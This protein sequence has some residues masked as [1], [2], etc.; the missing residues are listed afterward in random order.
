[1]V[2]RRRA[3]S[4][5]AVLAILTAITF[6]GD[7]RPARSANTKVVVQISADVVSDGRAPFSA[8]GDNGRGEDDG[9]TNGRVRVG[10][11]VTY[12]IEVG[13]NDPTTSIV[14]RYPVIV[15][16]ATLPIGFT[17]TSIPTACSGPDSDLLNDDRVL[18][19]DLGSRATGSSAGFNAVV[20]VA[21]DVHEGK[22]VRP[23]FRVSSSGF[24]DT[25]LDYPP[26]VVATSAAPSFDLFKSKVTT[27]VYKV[28]NGRAGY[29]FD[30]S[31]AIR[32]SRLVGMEP[33]DNSVTFVEN[34]DDVAPD[35]RLIGCTNSNVS[36]SSLPRTNNPSSNV[37]NF[38]S[39]T[40]RQ[41]GTV[42][43]T[44][45]EGAQV[46]TVEGVD[47]Q[48]SRYPTQTL[49]GGSIP[50]SEGIVHVGTLQVWIPRDSFTDVYLTSRNKLG[51]LRGT[52]AIT[53]CF[54]GDA[55]QPGHPDYDDAE[56]QL[57]FD[58]TCS[59]KFNEPGLGKDASDV[60]ASA[61][62]ADDGSQNHW[63]A[64]LYEPLGA[65]VQKYD[66]VWN[67]PTSAVPNG[68]V[69]YTGLSRFN[70]PVGSD[71][72]TG[73]GFIGRQTQFFSR[74]NFTGIGLFDFQPGLIL[75]TTIDNNVVRVD[76]L[77]GQSERAAW[78]DTSS[79]SAVISAAREA[80]WVIEYGVGGKDGSL[81][82]KETYDGLPTWGSRDDQKRGT[83]TDD[84]SAVWTQ[85][86]TSP[87]L[88]AYGG[89]W[90]VTKIRFRTTS[91]WTAESQEI[92]GTIRPSVSLRVRSAA[93]VGAIGAN[94]LNVYLPDVGWDW[95]ISSYNATTAK[96]E[97]G[98]RI[99]VTGTRV[100]IAK[101]VDSANV[102][103]GSGTPI[104]YTLQ[105][106]ITATDVEN[107]QTSHQ[108][109]VVDT[110]PEGVRYVVGSAAPS[111]DKVTV[112]LNGSTTLRWFLGDLTANE[113][114]TPITYQAMV[115]EDVPTG[116]YV[117][118]AVISSYFPGEAQ[119]SANFE[120]VSSETL[121][122]STATV[123][124]T[125]S[126]SF[127]IVKRTLTPRVEIG[128]QFSFDVSAVNL[129]ATTYNATSIIDWLPATT[130][131]RIAKSSFN[132]GVHVVSVTSNPGNSIAAEDLP[133]G[134]QIEYT[135]FD[136]GAA[137]FPADADPDTISGTIGWCST[138]GTPSTN[139]PASI[140]DTTA[141]RITT[142]TFEPGQKLRIRILLEPTQGSGGSLGI[143][144]RAGDVYTN[145]AVMRRQGTGIVL[146]S[147]LAAV[148]VGA[149]SLGDYVWRD[150]DG[151]G[152]QNGNEP[153]LSGVRVRLY[154]PNPFTG[155]PV[156]VSIGLD[157]ILGT[158]DDA[159]GGVVTN[160]QG[161]YSFAN[162]PHGR[163]IIR[164]DKP[165]KYVPTRQSVGDDSTIDSD[166][167]G[168]GWSMWVT[169]GV[170]SDNPNIDAGFEPVAHVVS[171]STTLSLEDTTYPSVGSNVPRVLAIMA[172]LLATGFVLRYGAGQRR[173]TPN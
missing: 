118:R 158:I 132:G 110:L 26:I 43:C 86:L 106:T 144:N 131:P 25:A 168:D 24:T 125:N 42:S 102:N 133:T 74:P 52:A 146:Q 105:P 62:P 3:T 124:V 104:N 156:E 8:A 81:A 169:L 7:A 71:W 68:A 98:D 100:R 117:N 173:Q 66:S 87:Q 150:S 48:P 107:D 134:I 41:N 34:V 157:G 72:R 80:G 75:C 44:T 95:L 155:E 137:T 84:D 6:F 85:D 13:L 59:G 121:R 61:N 135:D 90:A 152:L 92:A 120:D 36:F 94:Y 70:S 145:N 65:R 76:P 45:G 113:A 60:L 50:T 51:A 23:S 56:P 103:A 122:S 136:P 40:I 39:A 142:G 17:F 1:M 35:A 116:T 99:T 164:F 149:S 171:T 16:S 130:E 57:N 83:C 22:T 91:E 138:I 4:I 82:D 112:N 49:G 172:L 111:P 109:T 89:R 115:D 73:D 63:T 37:T 32:R 96:G 11:V 93:A 148:E 166:I 30:W 162:L 19:C 163:Y 153:S 20:R 159:A 9:P 46:V 161:K 151:D 170:D 108:V 10:D 123:S 78:I 58:P 64:V 101:S 167:D 143:T 29:Q 114:Q 55:V 119:V 47:W 154:V 129:G 141:I 38:P 147:N 127:A 79:S 28:I 54:D 128:E 88:A 77:P 67:M 69:G 139:C 97:R 18:V 160:A 31:Y 2:T 140:A 15:T 14:A 12:G 33:L 53:R 126:S 21:D 27:G 5:A 165:T